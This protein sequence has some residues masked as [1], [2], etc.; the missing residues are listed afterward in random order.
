[1]NNVKEFMIASLEQ[2]QLL[3][4][5]DETKSRYTID[6]NEVTNWFKQLDNRLNNAYE[7]MGEDC[8]SHYTNRNAVVCGDDVFLCVEDL[9][10]ILKCLNEVHFKCSLRI[11]LKNFV[12]NVSTILNFKTERLIDSFVIVVS[13]TEYSISKE[14]LDRLLFDIRPYFFGCKILGSYDALLHYG[15]FSMHS[16]CSTNL[17]IDLFDAEIDKL[18]PDN[19]KSCDGRISTIVYS[20][21]YVYPC[22]GLVGLKNAAIDK[23]NASP[24]EMKIFEERRKPLLEWYKDGPKLENEDIIVESE[25]LPYYCRRHRAQLIEQSKGN[26]F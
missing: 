25:E 17:D 15:F 2:L 12:E 21:G 8:P 19:K 13:D 1:M 24:D 26:C 10:K 6:A 20:D 7:T 18:Y 16:V 22:E 3:L 4:N 11:S 23:I 9:K 5:A 14:E